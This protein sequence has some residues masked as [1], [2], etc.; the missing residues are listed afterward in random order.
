ME[1]FKTQTEEKILGNGE[2]PEIRKKRT[3]NKKCT[4]PELPEHPAKEKKV[5]K[6]KFE[7]K[8]ATAKANEIQAKEMRRGSCDLGSD[9]EWKEGRE[10]R[11]R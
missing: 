1:K 2:N 10:E 9:G 4:K 8:T 11:D 5:G 3:T 7:N 6:I